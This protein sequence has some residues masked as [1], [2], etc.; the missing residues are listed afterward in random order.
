MIKF[1]VIAGRNETLALPSANRHNIIVSGH[2]TAFTVGIM[3]QLDIETIMRIMTL[4]L[5]IS[6]SIAFV[7]L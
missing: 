4:V 5:L 3:G 1:N 7:Y 6:L 2:Q